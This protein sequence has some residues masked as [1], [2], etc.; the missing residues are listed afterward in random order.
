MKGRHFHERLGFALAG[1]RAGWAREASF[2][3]Q[4]RFAAAAVV[5]LIVLHPQPIWWAVV[6]LVVAMILALELLNSAIEGIIDLLH[7]GLHPEIK[8]VKDMV[9]GAVL[10]TSMAA[11][12]IGVA[13][14]VERV[15]ALMESWWQ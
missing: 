6:L 4:V 11:L 2:R 13:L 9:A 3:T 15:P 14:V 1:L 7:P 5:V 10:V 8:A 12:T